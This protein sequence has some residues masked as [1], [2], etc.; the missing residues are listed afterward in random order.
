MDFIV[1]AAMRILYYDLI[2]EFPSS[3]DNNENVTADIRMNE[4]YKE[5]G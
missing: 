5:K 3:D 1:S 4:G 2:Y